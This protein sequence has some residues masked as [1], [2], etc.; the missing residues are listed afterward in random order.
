MEPG[1]SQGQDGLVNTRAVGRVSSDQAFGR[2]RNH[3]SNLVNRKQLREAKRL[4]PDRTA[5][6]TA[7]TEVKPGPVTPKGS[8]LP[9]LTGTLGQEGT[10]GRADSQGGNVRSA[11]PPASNKEVGP[12]PGLSCSLCKMGTV[13]PVSSTGVVW[14]FALRWKHP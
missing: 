3:H 11:P 6:S 7:E 14:Q 13:T 5:I 4:A 2:D 1:Q 9:G 12:L 10:W 8:V